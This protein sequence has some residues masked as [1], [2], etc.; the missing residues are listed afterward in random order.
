VANATQ[1][2]LSSCVFTRDVGRGLRFGLGLQAGMTHINDSSVY[3]A[4]TGPFGGEKNSGLGRF[5]GEWI[6]HEFT[7]DHRVTVQH[8]QLTYPS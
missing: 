1:F 3:D 7:R 8:S 5:G 4:P 2:G 6:I